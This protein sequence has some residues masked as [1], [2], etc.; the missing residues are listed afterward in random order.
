MCPAMLIPWLSQR[1]KS[2]LQLG[3][4]C[5]ASAMCAFAL[6]VVATANDDDDDDD[7]DGDSS[8]R[9]C[10]ANGKAHIMSTD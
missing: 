7:G 5:I 10:V 3:A 6:L 9:V 1:L 2:I 8:S 4:H